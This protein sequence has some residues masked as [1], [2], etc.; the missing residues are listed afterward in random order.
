M[1]YLNDKAKKHLQPLAVELEASMVMPLDVSA[2]RKCRS[3][4]VLR[5]PRSARAAKLSTARSS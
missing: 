4:G 3:A 5:T 2:S 1:T